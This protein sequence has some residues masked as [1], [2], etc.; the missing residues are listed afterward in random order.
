MPI[1]LPVLVRRSARDTTVPATRPA[2][3][4]C[5]TE[6]QNAVQRWTFSRFEDRRVIVERMAGEEEADRV[7]L[8]L[9]PLRRQPRLA[10]PACAAPRASRRRRT[11]RSGR[12]P[13]PRAGAAPPRGSRRRRHG[14]A[15]GCRSSASNAPG[16]AQAF[17]HALVDRARIDAACEV[18]RRRGTACRRAPRRSPSTASRADALERRE[19]VVD[20]VALDVEIRARAIDRRR[21]DLDAEPLR[22]RRGIPTACRYSPCRRSSTRRGTRPDSSPSC[23]R[24]GRRPARRRPRGSC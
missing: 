23:R 2:V 4:P 17:Q 20:R 21:L 22:P 24:S 6:L 13:R 9:Q 7:E 16:G 10:P 8:A 1:L 18:R 11:V 14:R 19:R 3:A 12:P 5:F 15:R